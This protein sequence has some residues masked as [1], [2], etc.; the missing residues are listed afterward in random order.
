MFSLGSSGG[1]DIALITI[2][3]SW[4]FSA[5]AILAVGA[6]VWSRRATG[7]GLKTDDYTLFV[8]FVITLVMVVQTT[9]AIIDESQDKHAVDMSKTQLTLAFRVLPPS[10]VY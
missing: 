7:V 6:L 4:V 10:V 3:C 5:V 2:I 9:W 1:P 8:A